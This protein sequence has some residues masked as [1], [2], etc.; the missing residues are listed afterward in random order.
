MQCFCYSQGNSESGFHFLPWEEGVETSIICWFKA[1]FYVLTE[2]FAGDLK[3][4]INPLFT[5]EEGKNIFFSQHFLGKLHKAQQLLRTTLQ[6]CSGFPWA[7]VHKYGPP[8][9]K[10]L[11]HPP[12]NKNLIEFSWDK[13]SVMALL[14]MHR[15][16]VC[17]HQAIEMGFHLGCR[18]GFVHD[19]VPSNQLSYCD[20]AEIY[21]L[22]FSNT[23][24]CTYKPFN[25]LI[26][27]WFWPCVFW[28]SAFSF[29]P[30]TPTLLTA[31][32]IWC[33]LSFR[34]EE[35]LNNSLWGWCWYHFLQWHL[36]TCLS[37]Q[38]CFKFVLVHRIQGK[39]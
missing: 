11:L 29:L 5:W 16:S 4:S 3:D 33:F 32:A 37:D 39:K 14:Q 9:G 34:P 17:P 21:Y 1:I 10:R 26:H 20:L 27:C 18:L 6:H 22:F 30:E 23:S 35:E 31:R 38:D 24:Q 36:Q 13:M 19:H 7:L 28:I 15:Y 12:W 25:L 2:C 8:L